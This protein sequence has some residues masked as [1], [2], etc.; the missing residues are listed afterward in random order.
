MGHHRF[1]KRCMSCIKAAH[2]S[3]NQGLKGAA[4]KLYC[5]ALE[6]YFYLGR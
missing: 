2:N 6:K 4:A 1:K 3:L 5:P